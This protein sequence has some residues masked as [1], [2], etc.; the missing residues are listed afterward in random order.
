MTLL[1]RVVAIQIS[2]RGRFVLLEVES[3]PK[4]GLSLRR[5]HIPS[6]ILQLG[7]RVKLTAE[8]WTKP[9]AVIQP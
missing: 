7:D 9:A 4:D 6:E 3:L 1:T 5:F 8:L 2:V